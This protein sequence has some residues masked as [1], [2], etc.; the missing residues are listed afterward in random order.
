MLSD[1]VLSQETLQKSC[2]WIWSCGGGIPVSFHKCKRFA[3]WQ[4]S[5]TFSGLFFVNIF[6][7]QR[8]FKGQFWFIAN[9]FVIW[10]WQCSSHQSICWNLATSPQT[11]PTGQKTHSN[12]ISPECLTGLCK[13]NILEVL[14]CSKVSAIDH[15][16]IINSSNLVFVIMWGYRLRL[17]CFRP[18][19]VFFSVEVKVSISEIKVLFT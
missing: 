17:E 14:P 10:L 12:Q 16:L 15:S 18:E 9:H 8:E 4:F 6:C 11:S 3:L 7:F 5:V 1:F 13:T 2:S 19:Q